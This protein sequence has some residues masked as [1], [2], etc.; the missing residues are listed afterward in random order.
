MTE[1]QDRLRRKLK[2][3]DILCLTLHLELLVRAPHSSLYINTG[4]M[5]GMR[6][7]AIVCLG[8]KKAGDDVSFKPFLS[9]VGQRTD[10]NWPYVP[11]VSLLCEPGAG[12]GLQK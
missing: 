1:S 12:A 9:L 11:C 4:A 3:E 6:D 8:G 7:G 5:V 2:A 10:S